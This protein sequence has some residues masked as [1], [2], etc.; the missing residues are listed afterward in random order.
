MSHQEDAFEQR[1]AG[2]W[3]V[4][5]PREVVFVAGQTA[6]TEALQAWSVLDTVLKA[7]C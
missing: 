7:W 3:T 4:C 5:F 2:D 1:Q 6:S